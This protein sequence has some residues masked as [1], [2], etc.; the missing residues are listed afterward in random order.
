[1]AKCAPEAIKGV[2]YGFCDQEAQ[3]WI[4]VPILR[5]SDLEKGTYHQGVYAL[6]GRHLDIY[7]GQ[8]QDVKV[9]PYKPN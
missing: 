6:C 2:S 5:G 3:E 4:Y 8:F 1:M 7:K 9:L